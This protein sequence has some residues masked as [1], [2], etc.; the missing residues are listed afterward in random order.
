MF[1]LVVLDLV[2]MVVLYLVTDWNLGGMPAEFIVVLLISTSVLDVHSTVLGVKRFGSSEIEGN[3]VA[4]VLI[5][6]LGPVGGSLFLKSFLIPL[7]FIN[8]YVGS[9]L[10]PLAALAIVFGLVATN[11]Y[12]TIWHLKL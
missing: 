4:R 11:N 3:P 12:L 6:K 5:N 8:L 7:V 10:L 2:I 1:A 9:S